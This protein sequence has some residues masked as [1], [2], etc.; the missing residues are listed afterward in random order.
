MM[1]SHSV[2][3]RNQT[4]RG[5][6]AKPFKG[7]KYVF[8]DNKIYKSRYSSV[9]HEDK[10]IYKTVKV[11]SYIRDNFRLLTRRS[12]S[13]D[14][15]RGNRF[16]RKLGIRVPKIHFW[17]ASPM[18]FDFNE[19]LIIENLE[20]HLTVEHHIS[21]YREHGVL[22]KILT[23]IAKDINLMAKNGAI[24]RDLHFQNVM[25]TLEGK[26]CWIDTGLKYIHST[27]KLNRKLKVKIGVVKRDMFDSKHLD[28]RE[29]NLFE[30]QLE[31]GK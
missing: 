17:G 21:A 24:Y 28:E 6:F 18:S 10:Y 22:D 31:F 23:D 25:A 1:S 12:K 13:Y 3:F 20:Y 4:F 9:Y 2:T 26:I 27:E 14:E 11:S 8:S 16:L 30:S 5:K 15:I 29:W 19:L 7:K